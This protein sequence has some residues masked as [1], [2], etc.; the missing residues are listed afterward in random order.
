VHLER[1]EKL[2]AFPPNNRQPIDYA[3]PGAEHPPQTRVQVHRVEN[4]MRFVDPPLAGSR[5]GHRIIVQLVVQIAASVGVLLLIVAGWRLSFQILFTVVSVGAVINTWLSLRYWRCSALYPTVIDIATDAMIVTQPT[6]KRIVIPF[7]DLADIRASR[8]RLMLGLPR[9]T[10]FL[11]IAAEGRKLRLLRYRDYVEI[12]WL[13]RQLRIATGRTADHPGEPPVQVGADAQEPGHSDKVW[14]G[15]LPPW[16]EAGRLEDEVVNKA[17][18]RQ[19]LSREYNNLGCG[20]TACLFLVVILGMFVICFGAD[21]LVICLQF[22]M[23][24]YFHKG[25]RRVP[26]RGFFVLNNGQ[27]VALQYQ[28]LFFAIYI[29]GMALWATLALCITIGVKNFLIGPRAGEKREHH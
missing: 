3:R 26:H 18:I 10:S 24:A 27:T 12:S 5:L 20:A 9:R 21:G 1:C 28:V 15:Q 13:A 6:R 7:R 8:P 22:G 17:S 25:L 4:G 2:E 23:D 29:V 14:S 16:T 11:V 19:T